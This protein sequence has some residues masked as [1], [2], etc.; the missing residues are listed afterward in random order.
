LGAVWASPAGAIDVPVVGAN[1]PSA[2][3]ATRLSLVGPDPPPFAAEQLISDMATTSAV[4]VDRTYRTG[5]S[6]VRTD[7]QSEHRTNTYT[8]D[9]TDYVLLSSGM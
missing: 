6:H 7:E 5:P 8:P 3:G 9:R 4:A 1:A 2:A